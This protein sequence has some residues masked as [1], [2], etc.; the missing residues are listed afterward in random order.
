MAFAPFSHHPFSLPKCGVVHPPKCLVWVC[1]NFITFA[2]WASSGFHNHNGL[3]YLEKWALP[4][5]FSLYIQWEQPEKVGG[6]KPNASHGFQ[7]YHLVCPPKPSS[8]QPILH[9]C[10]RYECV[11]GY[12]WKQSFWNHTNYMRCMLIMVFKL[13]SGLYSKSIL[14]STY[15]T[16][17][18]KIRM[19]PRI[20]FETECLKLYQLQS[21]IKW[22][23]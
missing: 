12:F 16:P 18:Y 14:I 4:T 7:T 3:T 17:L 20:L 19:C 21:P 6:V 10:T 13:L 22:S 11:R 8:Y 5:S 23:L 9:L 15:I 1:A 2:I